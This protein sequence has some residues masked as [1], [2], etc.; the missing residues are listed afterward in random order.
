MDVDF[1]N[2]FDLDEGVMGKK[3]YGYETEELI[4][5]DVSSIGFYW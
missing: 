5:R 4:L 1:V 2:G 3:C